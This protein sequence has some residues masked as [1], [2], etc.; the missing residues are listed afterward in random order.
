[1]TFIP[2]E[3]MH[4]LVLGLKPISRLIQRYHRTGI[5]S[6]SG[7]VEAVFKMYSRF[8]SP[9]GKDVLEIGPGQTLE[10]LK[11]ALAAG[12][13]SCTA[14]DVLRYVPEHQTKS[15]QIAYIIYDGRRLPF[16]AGRFDCIWSHTAFEHVRNPTITVA[17]CFRV[18]RTGGR[19][20]ALIDLG[21]HSHYRM[22]P[23]QPLN[24]FDCLRYPEWL[25]KLMKWNR[26]SYTNRLRKSDWIKLFTESGFVIE[27]QESVVSHVIAEALPSLPYLHRYSH[28]DAVTHVITLWLKKPRA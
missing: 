26:S 11:T 5:N 21:D 25:W 20:V 22:H 27:H 7:K 19:L 8:D 24:L 1:M 13:A 17:E 12:A 6:E 23:P 18:L 3:I 4:N 28:E 2:F 10:V 9:R 14:V 16:N 15:K